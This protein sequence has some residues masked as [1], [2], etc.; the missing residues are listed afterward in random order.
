MDDVIA[1]LQSVFG[2]SVFPDALFYR[3][4]AALRFEL[5]GE[6]FSVNGRP[7][8][9]F[10]QAVIRA[11]SVAEAVFEKSSSIT[12]LVSHYDRP[13][14]SAAK[15]RGITATG[16]ARKDFSLVASTAQNDDE[17]RADF[18]EDLFL[19]QFVYNGDARHVL[20]DVLWLAV[21]KEMPIRP[22]VRWLSVYLVDFDR[23]ICLHPYD[24][25]G[26]DLVVMDPATLAPIYRA[27]GDWLLPYDRARMD[28][29]F[30][31]G[32]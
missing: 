30:G 2:L 27:F 12:L 1:K 25:R 17:Y 6:T 21:A 26:M 3:F 31:I 15:F 32:R 14:P 24:D 18:G 20:A 11:I 5:G 7:L 22:E 19:H 8:Q 23:G 10:L 16:L 29:T 28:A 13:K 4:E 9:R